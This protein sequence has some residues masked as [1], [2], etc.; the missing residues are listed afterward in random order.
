MAS[1][2]VAARLH[3]RAVG[4]IIRA[5]IADASEPL[6]R[7]K[8]RLL[9]ASEAEIR[10]V[11]ECHEGRQT[12]DAIRTCRPDLLLLDIQMPDLDGFQVLSELSPDEMPV[13]IFTS[14]YDQYAIRASR[15]MLWIIS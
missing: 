6:A 14:A 3:D 8:L 15:P 5:I 7:T 13:V 12:V 9:L 4:F 1:E 11:A 2:L 10:V